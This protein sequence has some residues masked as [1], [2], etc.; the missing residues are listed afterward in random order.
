MSST[1][2]THRAAA[3][4]HDPWPARTPVS[5]TELDPLAFLRRSATLHPD[6]VAV[7]H[8]DLRRTS[9]ELDARVSRL[10]SALRGRGLAP[11]DRVAVLS[12]NAPAL[13]EAHFGVPAA[14]GVLV[15][16]N[17]RLSAPEI[18]A[19]LEHSG[20]R[21]LLADAELMVSVPDPPPG[22]EVV[23]VDDTGAPD[24]PYQQLLAEGDPAAAP[25]VVADEEDP[26]SIN[27][28]SGTT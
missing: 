9:G 15:A 26:I 4:R 18:R 25:R 20:A 7:V 13:L 5:R 12:P 1:D 21:F 17:A 23:R 3:P 8:G 28:T 19:I 24:D 22:L 16:I 2:A 14:G 27:Y 6:R 10:A 11:R